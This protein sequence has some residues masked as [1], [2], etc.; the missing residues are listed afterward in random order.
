MF[1]P[2][3]TIVAIATAAGR[4]AIGLV[5]ISGPE[6]LR[7]SASVLDRS[8]IEPRRATI[9]RIGGSSSLS[10][11]DE[12]VV[13]WF[14]A[15]ASYT[16]QDVVEISAHGSPVVLEAIVRRS[17]DAGARLARP[18]EF[19]LRAF[20]NG[21]RDLIQ[22]EAVGDLIAA[23][24]PLQARTAF[25]QLEGTLSERI[26]SVDALV[27]D[28]LVR[29]EASIDFPDEGYHFVNPGEVVAG[30]DVALQRIDALLCDSLRG[31]MIR[32]GAIVVIAGRTNVGKSSLFNALAGSERA[33][34]TPI[35]GT[36]RDLV[37]ERV[38]INGF[39]VTL[40]D[41][42]GSRETEDV[43]ER[44]GVMRGG[45]AR[46]SA[47]LVLVVV[48]ASAPI[49]SE[50]DRLL[51]DTSATRRLIVANKCDLASAAS[52]ADN[53]A[54]PGQPTCR[55]SA[56][57]S[58]GL[59][60]LRENIVSALGVGES[61]REAAAVSNV[62][63]VDLLQRARTHLGAARTAAATTTPEEFIL[64]D[65]QA[66]RACFDEIVGAR[67]TEDILEQVFA[68]FCIGK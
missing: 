2:D 40:V 24:T 51:Q 22:A 53:V 33:I 4:A 61:P 63:H 1:A 13:T 56:V 54:L 32:E 37:T 39:E 42:A 55:V 50:D 45:R 23:A 67:T 28:L 27:F 65:L 17:I 34:V 57:T 11:L 58:E 44:E 59:E 48:D 3:D 5:R 38:D 47:D 31:R 18:G 52:S 29:L 7:V 68:R 60:S 41:T 16:G 35:A 25:D 46:E 62:R 10:T 66:A 49:T 14:A 12:V 64:T 21:K 30:L 15:P 8:P 36:T 20:L 26:A 43:I 6:A 19:T 9:A